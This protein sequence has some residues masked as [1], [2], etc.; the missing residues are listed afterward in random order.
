MRATIPTS[1]VVR[2][3]PDIRGSSTR[4]R[5]AVA[6]TASRLIRSPPTGERV[7]PPCCDLIRV[8]GFLLMRLAF[9]GKSLVGVHRCDTR[10][11]WSLHVF[12]RFPG[13]GAFGPGTRWSPWPVV[14]ITWCVDPEP[15][16]RRARTNQGPGDDPGPWMNGNGG[17][18]EGREPHR[19]SLGCRE[20]ER[21]ALLAAYAGETRHPGVPYTSSGGGWRMGHATHTSK[22]VSSTQDPDGESTAWIAD[23]SAPHRK[24][25][26]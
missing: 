17:E 1:P 10:P 5:E 15:S 19:R 8:P 13:N 4:W 24:L 6:S 23:P 3:R 14:R 12:G 16:A 22:C 21:C 25:I 20:V 9:L 26:E 2:L 7:C 18:R 11:W